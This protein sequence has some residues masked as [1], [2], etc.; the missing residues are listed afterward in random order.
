MSFSPTIPLTAEAWK[1]FRVSDDVYASFKTIKDPESEY[2]N[3]KYHPE[4]TVM[5]QNALAATD[6]VTKVTSYSF[7]TS[8]PVFKNVNFWSATDHTL[9]AQNDNQAGAH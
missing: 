4:R 6:P 7:I 2:Y 3:T 9:L 8:D 5:L 1:L